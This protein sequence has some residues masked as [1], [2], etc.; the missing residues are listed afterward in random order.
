MVQGIMELIFD[1]AYLIFA[2]AVGIYLTVRGKS[3]FFKLFGVMAIVLSSA[4]RFISCRA[5]MRC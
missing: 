2:M 4:M 5:Y 3:T 1:A